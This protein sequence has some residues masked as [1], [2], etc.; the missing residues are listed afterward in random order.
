[1][2]VET[3]LPLARA[4]DPLLGARVNLEMAVPSI[5]PNGAARLP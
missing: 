1:M 5:A 3:L 2:I 4:R